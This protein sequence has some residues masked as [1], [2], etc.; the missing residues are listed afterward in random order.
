MVRKMGPKRFKK[1]KEF[2]LKYGIDLYNLE[3]ESSDSGC[4]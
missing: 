2:C 3:T 1:W 4:L